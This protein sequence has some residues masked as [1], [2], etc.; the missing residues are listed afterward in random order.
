ML[1]QIREILLPGSS[2]VASEVDRVASEEDRVASE[3]DR[4]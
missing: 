4:D 3:K 1:E 2:R